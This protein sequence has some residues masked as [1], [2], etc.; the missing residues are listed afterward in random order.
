MIKKAKLISVS[1]GKNTTKEKYRTRIIQYGEVKKKSAIT[2]RIKRQ[3]QEW[4][5]KR[6]GRILRQSRIESDQ[7]AARTADQSEGAISLQATR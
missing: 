1:E 7:S 2:V 6:S 4:I 5:E 3:N